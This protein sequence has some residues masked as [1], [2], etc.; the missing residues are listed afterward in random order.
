MAAYQIDIHHA[1]GETADVGDIVR[2]IDV[3]FTA[4]GRIRRESLVINRIRPGDV[5]VGMASY[6]CST[7]ESEYNS[8]IGSNGLTSARHDVLHHDYAKKYPETYSEQT[9][10]KYVYS[11]SRIVDDKIRINDGL[12]SVGKM[13]LSPT[14]TYLPVL[15]T[16]LRELRGDIHG[17]IHNTGGG[18]SKVRRFLPD[19]V[20]VVKDNLPVCPPVFELVQ[21]ESG[22]TWEEM[23]QVFNMGTRMEV[24]VPDSVADEIISMAGAYQIDAWVTGRVEKA[25]ASAVILETPYGTFTYR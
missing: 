4:F 6:G 25:D 20:R 21:S 17:L 1:G 11:G 24:Y 19:D 14:R 2:T 18:Q 12:F 15:H 16:I 22:T 7:Y 5:V 3:G 8:G 23:Y 9:D 10:R 13:L